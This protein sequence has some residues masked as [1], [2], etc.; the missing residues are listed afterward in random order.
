MSF[1]VVRAR[2]F[3]RDLE[4]FTRYT[5]AYSDAFSREQF[6]RLNRILT[7][8]LAEKPKTWSYFFITGA[9]YRAYLFRVGR[10]T[11]YW[12][13]YKIDEATRRVDVL[14]L[15]NASRKIETFEL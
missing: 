8:D 13:V 4:D 1:T 5:S 15:W 9:P 12:V 2:R 7:V 11:S 6:E 14:R 10:R 3:N